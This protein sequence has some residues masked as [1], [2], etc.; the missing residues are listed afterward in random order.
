MS[1]LSALM[2]WTWVM[3]SSFYSYHNLSKWSVFR[4]R[5]YR[6]LMILLFC[7]FH[8][9]IPST[10]PIFFGPTVWRLRVAWIVP[11]N[12]S[13]TAPVNSR[14]MK[15]LSG[16]WGLGLRLS[17]KLNHMLFS[18]FVSSIPHPFEFRVLMLKILES[19]DTWCMEV[20]QGP[21]REV[22]S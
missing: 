12:I 2:T 20:S 15:I 14:I 10:S 5:V 9:H 18:L 16:I 6:M 21:Q 7:H 3:F 17:F 1:I 11:Q 22:I 4:C 8:N 19:K 13:L